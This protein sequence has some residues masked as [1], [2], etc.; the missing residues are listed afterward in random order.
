META[1]ANV[2]NVSP[3]T[4]SMCICLLGPLLGGVGEQC[5]DGVRRAQRQHLVM[6]RRDRVVELEL[7]NEDS[8]IVGAEYRV[9]GNRNYSSHVV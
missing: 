1:S 6:C 9:P 4:V 7:E 3:Q 5:Q 2:S 8:K